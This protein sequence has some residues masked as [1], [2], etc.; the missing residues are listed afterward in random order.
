MLKSNNIKLFKRQQRFEYLFRNLTKLFAAFI[1]CIFITII[2]FLFIESLPAIKA[3]RWKFFISTEWNPVKQHFGALVSIYGTI[4][5]SFIALLISVP[6]SF[7]IAIFLTQIAPLKLRNPLRILIE[8]LASIPSIIYGMWGLFI[9][10]P[11]FGHYVQP[12]LISHFGSLPGIGILFQGTPI[13]ICIFTAGII[14]SVM[15]IPFIAAVMRDVFAIAPDLLKESAYALGSTDWEVIWKVIVPYSRIGIIGAIML[16]LGR[17]LG[18]TIAVAFIIGNAHNWS[19]SLL[20]PGNTIAS[21]IANEFTEAIGALYTSALIE[22]GLIL[23][24]ITFIILV[25]AKLM[26]A[27]LKKNQ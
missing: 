19:P 3:F 24:L 16:G 22:L 9:F 14:L 20:M 27:Y 11:W 8:M 13:G 2:I 12:W 17:A 15:V 18:E 21:T 6:L 7:G 23:F 25:I 5:T 1:V 26:L 10:A 4:I